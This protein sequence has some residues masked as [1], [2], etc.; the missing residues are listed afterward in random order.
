MRYIS[1]PL[2]E[3]I[4][5][6]L[7]DYVYSSGFDY[8]YP[9]PIVSPRMNMIDFEKSPRLALLIYGVLLVSCLIEIS[10]E[11]GLHTFDGFASHHGMAI[12][13]LASLIDNWSNISQ[14]FNVWRSYE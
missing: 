7:G 2:A 12:F 14:H 3:I 13:A 1:L 8:C 4:K 5:T 10:V 9:C 11:L 6:K